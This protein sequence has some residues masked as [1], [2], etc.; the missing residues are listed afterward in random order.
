MEQKINWTGTELIS[1]AAS[2]EN[3]TEITN[4]TKL[5][6]LEELIEKNKILLKETNNFYSNYF[7]NSDLGSVVGRLE[8]NIIQLK[9]IKL[10]LLDV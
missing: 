3:K 7:T 1:S 6:V 8:Q 9:K 2:K 10:S 5:M 4:E